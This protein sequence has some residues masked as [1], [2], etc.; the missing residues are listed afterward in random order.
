MKKAV[1]AIIILLLA[2]MAGPT[3]ADGDLRL[4]NDRFV[5]RYASGD[6]RIAAELDRESISI[7][8]RIIADIGVDF[9]GKTEIRICPSIEA[10]REAQPRGTWIPLWAAGVAYPEE[11]LIV[12]RAPR[13]VKGSR[14]DLL[15]VFA[16]E[17]SH[18]ALGRALAG[19][20]GSG[21]AQRR[22]RDLRGAGVD[23]LPDRRPDEGRADGP[24]DPA[25]RAHPLLSGGDWNRRNWP[26]R[27]V[28]CSSPS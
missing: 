11:N 17:F 28:S 12:L 14:I 5:I 3:P 4:E 20:E 2:F 19:G 23:L 24:V 15:D 25:A 9:P 1:S 26:M 6:E 18:I 10:F 27:R 21:L 8:E 13:A 22:A 7:R 16:H